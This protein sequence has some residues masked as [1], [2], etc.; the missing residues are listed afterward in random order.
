MKIKYKQFPSN[1]D[2]WTIAEEGEGKDLE[3]RCSIDINGDTLQYYSSDS[4]DNYEDAEADFRKDIIEELKE[5]F[6]ENVENYDEFY[7]LISAI[8]LKASSILKHNFAEED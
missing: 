4:F 2:I 6:G 1:F 8:I 7:F 3:N 5:K